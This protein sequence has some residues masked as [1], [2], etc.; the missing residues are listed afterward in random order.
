M[1]INDP[2]D[3]IDRARD[4]WRAQR[5]E[6]DTAPMETVG[7]ILRVN[8]LAGIKMRSL[9]QRNGLDWGGV[10]VLAT[11]RRSGPPYRLT[12]TYLYRE[13][14]LTSGAMTHRIDALERATFVERRPDPEDRRG[15]LIGLTLKGRTLI[16]R[17]MDEHM[18]GE[19]QVAASLT[20][21]EQKTLAKLLKKLLLPL[22]SRNERE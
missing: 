1:Q 7:R 13:L 19:A 16:D 9:F 17:V 4:Q 12:P 6:L 5:P 22:E 14:V 2:L 21:A 10:D 15:S 20:R 8:F 3:E 18:K 11:L